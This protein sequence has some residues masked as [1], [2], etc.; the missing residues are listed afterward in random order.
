MLDRLVP[1]VL[2]SIPI[3]PLITTFSCLVLF[4]YINLL[5]F[6]LLFCVCLALNFPAIH[7]YIIPSCFLVAFMDGRNKVRMLHHLFL[8]VFLVLFLVSRS[9][10]LSKVLE[11]ALID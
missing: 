5:F 8:F 7:T 6:S 3:L 10:C 4:T 11:S 2:Q 1:I 9:Y